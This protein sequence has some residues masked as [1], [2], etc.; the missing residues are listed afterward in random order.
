MRP[1][2]PELKKYM[3]KKILFQLNANRKVSGVLRG[4]DAFMNIVLDEAMELIPKDDIKKEYIERPMGMIL[5]RGNSIVMME[6]L[7][8]SNVA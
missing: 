8:R 7:E 3:N 5:L 2:D 1:A 6:S 4:Y